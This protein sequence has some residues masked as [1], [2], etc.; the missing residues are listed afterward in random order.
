MYLTRRA[1]QQYSGIIETGQSARTEKSA[2][3]FFILHRRNSVPTIEKKPLPPIGSGS[4]TINPSDKEDITS[5]AR[6]VIDH[7]VSGKG[8]WWDEGPRKSAP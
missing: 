4:V 6:D 3:G 1:K 2:A 7:Y 8:S 5:R